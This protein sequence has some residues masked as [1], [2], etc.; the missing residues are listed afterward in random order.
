MDEIKA[1]STRFLVEDLKGMEVI[2]RL[3]LTLIPM[4]TVT[5]ASRVKT[6]SIDTG[7]GRTGT[8]TPCKPLLYLTPSIA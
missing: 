2:S 8:T 1:E 5:T 6:I 3:I 4:A 7:V